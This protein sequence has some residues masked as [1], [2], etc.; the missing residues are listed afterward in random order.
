MMRRTVAIDCFPEAARHYRDGWAVVAVDVIRAT[1]T[2]VTAVATG[3]RC[4]PVTSLHAALGAARRLPDALL[5]GELEGEKPAGFE[6]NNSPFDLEQREDVERPMIL[7]SSSGTRLICATGESRAAYVGSLRDYTAL[8]RHLAENHDRVAVIG[9]GSRGS[10]REEDQLCCAWI[11]S[12]L[13]GRGFEPA[14]PPTANLIRYWER[15][16]VESIAN[17]D[18]ARYLQRSGQV[19]D[20]QFVLTHVDDLQLVCR[21]DGGEVR[22][23]ATQPA[24]A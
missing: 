9:A 2:A 8:A 11:A 20:L 15:R 22:A 1:T 17:G 16:P 7:L 14:D 19:R 6:L 24:L 13:V 23:A 5:V 4:L 18:S 12:R 3:R 10:F 21:Y